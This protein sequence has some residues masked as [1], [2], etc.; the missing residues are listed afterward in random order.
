MYAQALRD[1][2]HRLALPFVDIHKAMSTY[3]RAV[4]N[5]DVK[6]DADSDDDA[7]YSRMDE[8]LCD[9]L[10]F[11]GKGNRMLFEEVCRMLHV[12]CR[13]CTVRYILH[14]FHSCTGECGYCKA[15]P[16]AH[17]RPV[18]HGGWSSRRRRRSRR[19]VSAHVHVYRRSL[20]NSFPTTSTLILRIW[21]H[22]CG[23]SSG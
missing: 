18:A 8:L 23:H 13:I 2:A 1:T 4:S 15:L 9:G 14:G 17:S 7:F 20:Q 16:R 21:I 5:G 12:A 6:D 11:S 3:A 10:H 22:Q 19:R